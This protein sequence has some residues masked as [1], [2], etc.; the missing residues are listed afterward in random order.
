[1]DIEPYGRGHRVEGVRV[2]TLLEQ[3]PQHRARAS[4]AADHPD[5]RRT[6]PDRP[7]QR[8]FVHPVAARNEHDVAVRIELEPLERALHV[9][10]DHMLGHWEAVAVREFLAVVDHGDRESRD[11]PDG[12]EGMP[13]VARAD[14]DELRGR[15]EQLEH[16]LRVVLTRRGTSIREATVR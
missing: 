4:P 7:P 3:V 1:P 9:L 6:P 12:G 11:L 10:A 8:V 16:Q 15:L 5:V 14:D 13:N 2:N